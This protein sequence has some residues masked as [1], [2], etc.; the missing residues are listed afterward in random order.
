MFGLK[1]IKPII[2][3]FAIVLL[4]CGDKMPL[5]SVTGSPESFGAN[6]TS[7]IHLQP[8]WNASTMGY[9]AT[10][11]L[12]PVD[13][14]IGADSYIFIADQGNNKI[15]AVTESGQLVT[16]YNMY[17]ISNID[18]PPQVSDKSKNLTI[19]Y[20]VQICA[21]QPFNC[22]CESLFFWNFH[23]IIQFFLT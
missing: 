2:L 10:N 19:C 7:Y 20:S 5:P 16:S 15:F 8:D 22:F 11:P 12:R 13:I 21:F 18:N 23:F 17:G 1:Y 9:F 14:A 4:G 3:I 6:D